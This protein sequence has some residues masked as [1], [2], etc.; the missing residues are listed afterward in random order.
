MQAITV[1]YLAVTDT[2]PTRYKA[3]CEGGSVTTSD[4]GFDR[5]EDNYCYACALLMSK[6]GWTG[7]MIGGGSKNGMVFVSDEP[8]YV[9]ETSHNPETARNREPST[10]IR[11][12]LP[13]IA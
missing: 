9:A 6:M 8:L 3:T 12:L 4:P 7:K 11:P 2:K 10:V 5:Y 1:K 13:A